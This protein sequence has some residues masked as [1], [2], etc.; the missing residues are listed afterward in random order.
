[1]ADIF[2]ELRRDHGELLRMLYELAEAGADRQRLFPELYGRLFAHLGAE[3]DVFYEELL[4]VPTARE[5]ALEGFVEHRL[6][7]SLLAELAPGDPF[8]ERW[9]ATLAVLRITFGR[10]VSDEEGPT[11]DLAREAVPEERA[12][13][14]GGRFS[15]EKQ[16]HL[17][18][19]MAR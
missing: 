7:S 11:F 12:E 17:K 9:Q 16:R 10:H 3:Q 8:D 4:L 13:S 15:A 2:M 19:A 5:R 6:I 1:M 14:L 18:F